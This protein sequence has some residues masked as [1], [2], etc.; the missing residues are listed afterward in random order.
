MFYPALEELMKDDL[1]AHWQAGRQAGLLEGRQEGRQAGLLEGRQ[2]G[3]LEGRQEGRQ[4]G[5]LEGRQE[6]RQAGLLEGRQEGRQEGVIL[7]TANVYRKILGLDNAALT[8][9]IAAEFHLTAEQA[10]EY[11]RLS[12]EA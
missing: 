8:G 7:G 2:A 12:Q 9:K 1:N 10:A 3:L 11:V 5:L 4:A 6:G